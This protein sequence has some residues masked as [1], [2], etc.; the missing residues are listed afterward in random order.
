MITTSEFIFKQPVASVRLTKDTP[1]NRGV[2]EGV[3]VVDC[4]HSHTLVTREYS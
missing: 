3:R 4:I 2:S 1:I